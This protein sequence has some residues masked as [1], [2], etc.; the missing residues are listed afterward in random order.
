M[1]AAQGFYY[2]DSNINHKDLSFFITKF[3]KLFVRVFD[4][5]D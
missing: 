5:A 4:I 2:Y 1:V 3:D